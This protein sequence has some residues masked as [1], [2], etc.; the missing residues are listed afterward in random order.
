MTLRWYV[1]A[2]RFWTSDIRRRYQ[3]AFGFV[4]HSV[5]QASIITLDVLEVCD[6]KRK[7]RQVRMQ[8]VNLDALQGTV[9]AAKHFGDCLDELFYAYFIYSA[10]LAY[11][12]IAMVRILTSQKSI[13]LRRCANS[14]P[15]RSQ[16]SPLYLK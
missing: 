13:F 11:D 10:A 7:N 12:K 4:F 6:I 1:R 2:R 15:F 14:R 16:F 5:V 9:G 8:M 3:V